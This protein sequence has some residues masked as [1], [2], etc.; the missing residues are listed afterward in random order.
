[1]RKMR[2]AGLFGALTLVA[3]L[4][5]TGIATAGE[6]TEN[7]VTQTADLTVSPTKLPKKKTKKVDPKDVS[8]NVD[9]G[10]TSDDPANKVPSA[11]RVELDFDKDL[12]FNTKGIPT[13]DANTIAT[14]NNEQAKAAC[15]K[16]LVGS[17][18][19][20][21]TCSP[22]EDPPDIPGV[23]VNAFNG[24]P[25]GKNPVLL[26]HTDAN[27][28]GNSTITILPGVLKKAGGAFGRTLDVT[29]PPLAGGA[30]SIV[31]FETTV[32]KGQINKKYSDYVAGTCRDRE[33]DMAGRFHFNSNPQ[34]V[35]QLNPTD[36]IVCKQKK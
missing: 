4:V 33:I 12:T 14:L 32:G 34:N 9:V 31:D 25:K 3:A 2:K 24:E 27:L 1:M 6:A 35:S 36:T 26:L 10:I 20:A 18:T 19:A 17:G 16:A 7:G 15:K 23:L 5:V 29:V 8:L 22:N 21:A 30:C 13:C 28:G 11:N